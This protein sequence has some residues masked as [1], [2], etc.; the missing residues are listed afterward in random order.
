MIKVMKPS[1]GAF[2][3]PEIDRLVEEFGRRDVLRAA[4]GAMIRRRAVV[5]DAGDLPAHIRRDIGLPPEAALRDWRLL[6]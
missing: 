4:L 2:L 5:M 6:R 3:R 1:P